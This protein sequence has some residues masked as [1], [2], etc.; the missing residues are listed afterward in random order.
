MSRRACHDRAVI[1]VRRRRPEDLEELTEVLVA[2]Q[3]STRYPFRNPLPIPIHDFLH[4]DDA[5]GAWTAEIDGA[6]VG[7]IVYT[8]DRDDFPGLA[9]M[10]RTCAGAH[11]CDADRL[12]WISAFFVAGDRRGKG[13]GRSLL[14]TA[15]DEIRRSGLH[16]CLEVLPVHPGALALYAST[17]WREVMRLRPDWL[18]SEQGDEGPDVLVMVLPDESRG[19]P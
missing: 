3:P 8:R 5:D 7:H 15:V 19:L 1:E 13:I 16:P 11:G 12:A 4:A 18:T 2:Q 14:T 17:G 10:T 6:P 9:E